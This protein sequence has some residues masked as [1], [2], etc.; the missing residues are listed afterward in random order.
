MATH[1]IPPHPCWVCMIPRTH[2]LHWYLNCA[3]PPNR[4]T[5]IKHL[6]S[7]ME[8]MLLGCLIPNVHGCSRSAQGQQHSI[9]LVVTSCLCSNVSWLSLCQV[10]LL[11]FMPGPNGSHLKM[12]V[13][14]SAFYCGQLGCFEVNDLNGRYHG[15]VHVLK[16]YMWQIHKLQTFPVPMI[17]NLWINTEILRTPQI[18]LFFHLAPVL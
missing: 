12:D 4:R 9:I 16:F 17:P 13:R 1:L 15:D 7:E 6:A 3:H 2:C 18:M 8:A 5:P 11:S 14:Y 10:S